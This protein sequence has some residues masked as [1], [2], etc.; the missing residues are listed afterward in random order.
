[1]TKGPAIRVRQVTAEEFQR[2]RRRFA[3]RDHQSCACYLRAIAALR[4]ETL[5]HLAVEHQG[6]VVAIAA[7]R[8]HLVGRVGG[9]GVVAGGPLVALPGRDAAVSWTAALAALS[10]DGRRRRVH[11]H[12]RAPLTAHVD[13]WY[14]EPSDHHPSPLFEPYR[15]MVLAL[16]G[17]AGARRAAL[18]G[19]WR[20]HLRVAEDAGLA[21]DRPP[22]AEAWARMRPLFEEMLRRKQFDNQMPLEFW[23]DVL[24]D[25]QAEGEFHGLV[26]HDGT[27]DLT[28]T[29]VG[30]SGALATQLLAASSDAALALRAGYLA[31]WVAI[32][33]A[34]T[35]GHRWFDLGGV[36]RD[37]N[38]GGWQ[39][40]HGLRGREWCTPAPLTVAPRG[41]TGRLGEW[42]ERQ[43]NRLLGR[44]AGR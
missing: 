42:A 43:A 6:E 44:D 4:G 21:V 14:A 12:L 27:R 8:E 3:D 20:K 25:P 9:I 30:G 34:A 36:D 28:A 22:V 26:V 38:P 33:D 15:T 39:F 16:D 2:R 17:D 10:C 29:V 19:H 1:M 37:A 13:G 35:R 31:T 40:K 11:L 32:D 24:G 18:S 41:V 7:A 23:D 5:V